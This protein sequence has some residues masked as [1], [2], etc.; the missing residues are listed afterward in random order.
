[1]AFQLPESIDS[2]TPI[3]AA[4]HQLN[5]TAIRD[6]M[7]TNLVNKDGSV[8]MTGALLLPA[9]PTSNMQA[10]T[11]QYVDSGDAAQLSLTGGTMSGFITLTSSNPTSDNHATRKAYVDTQVAS[12]LPL[13]GGTLSGQL[14]ATGLVSTGNVQVANAIRTDGVLLYQ[15]TSG[16]NTGTLRG[17]TPYTDTT[18]TQRVLTTARQAANLSISFTPQRNGFVMLTAVCDFIQT[19]V[20][21]AT[22]VGELGYT[23]NA[24]STTYMT[25]IAAFSGPGG[26]S[27]ETRATVT[28]QWYLAVTAGN[29][30]VF[31]IWVK[32][33]L[34]NA[35]YTFLPDHSNLMAIVY[36]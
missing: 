6:H 28:Q 34:D 11:K 21:T 30:Y 19:S 14:T 13:T 3:V 10:A 18:A 17:I 24:G 35:G 12:R 20:G 2:G 32:K 9:N 5:Y 27:N 1:M 36:T 25:Q 22:A 23:V 7:N 8:A 26:G 33:N 29:A 4:E 31:N 16:T 15:N